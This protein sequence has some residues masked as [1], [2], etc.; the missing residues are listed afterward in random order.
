MALT[1]NLTS[2]WKFDESSGN[3]AD[4]VWS[5]T[6]TN[7]NTVSFAAGKINNGATYNGA[8]DRR[9][10]VSSGAGLNTVAI[11]VA[12][13]MKSSDNNRYIIY[14][15]G[16]NTDERMIIGN[17]S[18]FGTAG[19]L[20]VFFVNKTSPWPFSSTAGIYDWNRH[21]IVVTCDWTTIQGYID[22]VL[23]INQAA[24]GSLTTTGRTTYIGIR[25]EWWLSYPEYKWQLDELWIWSRVIT[26][27]EVTQ[28]WNWGA[29]LQY[30][31]IS[32][33]IK[34]IN[35]LAKASVKTVDWLVNASVKTVNWLA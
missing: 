9:F 33:A 21:H 13:R 17:Q 35:W 16:N 5:N 22:N 8:S 10:E 11:S 4:S 1:T 32:S 30:P 20:N 26:Q 18:W 27:A 12:F 3:A 2:Y 7:V 24:S 29:G 14:N 23:D 15:G 28:L 34:T 31:F 6:A 19:K 25:Y